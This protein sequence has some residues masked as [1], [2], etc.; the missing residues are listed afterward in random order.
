[1]NMNAPFRTEVFRPRGA[2]SFDERNPP[3]AREDGVLY[4]SRHKYA[5]HCEFFRLGGVQMERAFM[6]ADRAGKTVVGAYEVTVHL[7]GEYPARWEAAGSIARLIGG[8]RRIRARR[9]AT[10][11]N[12]RLWDLRASMERA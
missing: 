7:T 2:A 6:A 4:H 1:M 8:R 9:R 3:A 12:W 11:C 10:S 5:K